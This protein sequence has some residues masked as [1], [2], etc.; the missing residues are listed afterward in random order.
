[1]LAVEFGRI[2][3]SCY[4]AM[5]WRESLGPSATQADAWA[6]G[7]EGIEEFRILWDHINTKRGYPWESSPWVWVIEF[8]NRE[9]T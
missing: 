1:M 6:E 3:K 2:H 8:R 9:G 7:T 5:I 4:E